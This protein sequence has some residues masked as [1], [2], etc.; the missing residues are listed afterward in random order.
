MRNRMIGGTG[1]LALAIGLLLALA[2][3]V[4]EPAYGPG[5]YHPYHGYYH[6]YDR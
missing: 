1:R 2:G 4:V 6:G 5:Y 3:C